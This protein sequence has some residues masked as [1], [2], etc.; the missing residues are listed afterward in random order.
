MNAKPCHQA[1]R[2]HSRFFGLEV[3]DWLLLVP[4]L[5]F[6]LIVLQQ[7]ILGLV[8]T[9]V[10]AVGL[11]LFKAGRLPGHT[12]ALGLYLLISDFLAPLG[13]EQAP[14][15]PHQGETRDASNQAA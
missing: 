7:M 1:L 12:Q 3:Y 8:V 14:L 10:S 11:R 15:Y 2:D 4:G 9:L 6:C 13:Y 5:W